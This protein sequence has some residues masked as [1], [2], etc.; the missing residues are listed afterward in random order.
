MLVS[1]HLIGFQKMSEASRTEIAANK[2]ST[3]ADPAA[4]FCS[5]YHSRI[6]Q[7]GAHIVHFYVEFDIFN[8]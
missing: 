5:P 8:K 3:F 2:I 7:R 1:N 4:I 6:I